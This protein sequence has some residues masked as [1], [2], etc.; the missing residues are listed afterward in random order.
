MD[1]E[2]RRL[3]VQR[4]G[5]DP[6]RR[7]LCHHGAARTSR[8]TS[9]FH[10]GRST[11]RSRRSHRR[12]S[13]GSASISGGSSRG[14]S[15]RCRSSARPRRTTRSRSTSAA[16][17][18]GHSQRQRPGRL[19]LQLCPH[20][21]HGPRRGLQLLGDRDRR[22]RATTASRRRPSRSRS[23][24]ARPPARRSM[25]RACSRARR[26]RAAWSR[27][28]TATSSSAS[29]RPTPRATGSS[30]PRWPR[31]AHHHGGRRQQ[32]GRYEP[33]VGGDRRERLS[34]R[35]GGRNATQLDHD[36]RAGVRRRIRNLH[37][38]R[39]TRHRMSI[40]SI[41]LDRSAATRCAAVRGRGAGDGDRRGCRSSPSRSASLLNGAMPAA[42][43]V[44]YAPNETI[45]QAWDLGSPEPAGVGAGL[46]RHG[47]RRGRGR[48]LVSLPAPGRRAGEPL[49]RPRR[50]GTGRSAAS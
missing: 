34:R 8:G 28:S 25:P 31:A 12:P 15:S 18:L 42:M 41:V 6:A 48:H 20:L 26:R 29:W 32:L 16:T 47:A 7:E 17:V 33:P 3:D 21:D 40:S 1:R 44:A 50:R 30:R 46:G 35:P 24:A 19:E 49:G 5:D 4:H 13:P 23:A 38:T 22:V 27:S 45:D 39:C 14:A 10:P 36:A 37:A 9:A 11:R 43:P 2:Q